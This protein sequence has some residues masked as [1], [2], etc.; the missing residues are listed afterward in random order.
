MRILLRMARRPGR[1]MEY[2][3]V[4]R[5][6]LAAMWIRSQALL[7]EPLLRK[8]SM[9]LAQDGGGPMT[10]MSSSRGLNMVMKMEV[11]LLAALKRAERE[12][13]RRCGVVEWEKEKP[14][15]A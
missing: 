7:R 12:V 11:G 15:R 10:H 3:A 14:S 4:L 1:A 13:G 2:K 9:G 8:Y 6:V 5:S